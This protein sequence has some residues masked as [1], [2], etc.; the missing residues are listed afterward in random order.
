MRHG[1]P[2]LAPARRRVRRRRLRADRQALR[3]GGEA[4]GLGAARL[5]P[6][7][8]TGPPG[9]R[10][11]TSATRRSSRG[12]RRDALLRR[13]LP[14]S[15]VGLPRCSRRERGV[16]S[17]ASGTSS[18]FVGGVSPGQSL[19]QRDRGRPPRVRQGPHH[20]LSIPAAP[21][22]GSS[23]GSR[24]LLRTRE[25]VRGEMQVGTQRGNPFVPVPRVWDVDGYNERLL[26]G[27][28]DMSRKEHYRKG[29]A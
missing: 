24:T 2:G 10:R 5:L 6:S 9:S 12:T 13:E 11:S 19:R 17:R 28:A 16:Q 1:A 8:S 20:R 23:T 21:T 25:G 3:E 14:Y 18:E 4:F 7:T 26:R 22:T 15:N 29:A 27:R